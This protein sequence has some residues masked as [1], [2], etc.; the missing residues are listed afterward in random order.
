[1]LV[2]GS[3]SQVALYWSEGMTEWRSIAELAD[4]VPA[5]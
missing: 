3:V 1:M 4:G 2:E 5:V